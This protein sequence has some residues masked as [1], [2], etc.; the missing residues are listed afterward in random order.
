LLVATINAGKDKQ[1]MSQKLVNLII[2]LKQS[3]QNTEKEITDRVGIT[4]A[5]Y[6]CLKI[7]PGTKSLGC[8]E[9]A[10]NMNLSPSR[11]SRIID[12]MVD[13]KLLV[14]QT[15][16]SDRRRTDISLTDLGKRIQK[17]VSQE[18]D[19]CEKLLL[20]NLSEQQIELASEGIGAI[21]NVLDNRQEDK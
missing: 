13:K 10:D 20:T 17:S 4:D 16:K 11:A 21:L 8:N 3:C 14:R 5:E 18:L 15:G 2:A 6:H 9:L 7:I 12:G 1:Q 19:R